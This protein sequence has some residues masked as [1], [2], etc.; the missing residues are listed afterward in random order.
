MPSALSIWR[1][2]D[3]GK[4]EQIAE[5]SSDRTR[6]RAPINGNDVYEVD[7]KMKKW[8]AFMFLVAVV[9]SAGWLIYSREK[10]A[11]LEVAQTSLSARGFHQAMYYEKLAG[12][13]VHCLLCPHSCRLSE[14]RIGVCRAR[15]NVNGELVSLVYGNIASAHV[16]PIEK[17]P[18]FHVLPGSKAFSIATPGCNMRCLFCQNWEISQAFPWEVKSQQMTPE[19]VVDA[20]LKSGCKSIAFTYTEPIIYYEYALDI[21][22]LAK[23][24]GLKT[25]VV[26]N[27]YINPEPLRELLKTIDA[28]KVDF[29]AFNEKFYKELTGGS[30]DPVLQTMKIIKQQG[31][32]LE[33]VTLLV[34]G[35]NDSEEEIRGL[36]RWIHRNLDDDVPLHFSRFHPMHKLLNLPP[37]PVEKIIRARQIAMEE[38]LKYVYTGNIAYPEGDSTY[39][40]M[41]GKMAIE[42]QGYFVVKNNLINGVASD[43]E[44][45]PG[46]WE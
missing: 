43:N 13:R 27:G 6:Y 17:K 34:P 11:A 41:T 15:K 22:K 24:K 2:L 19:Q 5:P 16:D 23:K 14:G 42:R 32:W 9:G 35:K 39:S 31:V 45:I 30:L 40:P 3:I 12:G 7:V 18:F 25:V 38:G 26:S 33:V 1:A 28:Y 4:R 10:G 46:I 36:A 37:T 20:A 44:K 8:M 29:K 21:A